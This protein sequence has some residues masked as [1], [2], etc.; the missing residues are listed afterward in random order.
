V[1]E[2]VARDVTGIPCRSR[3]RADPSS[4][5]EMAR[6]WRAPAVVGRAMSRAADLLG[7]ALWRLPVAAP[8]ADHRATAWE[9]AL[10]ASY[11]GPGRGYTS[12]L[13]TVVAVRG[14]GERLA[15][16]RELARPQRPYM[17]ARGWSPLAP[18]RDAARRI[19]ASR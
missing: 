15:S 18:L 5:V 2:T 14:A 19:W 3:V 12:Q 9:R 11:R 1:R 7:Q 4:V 17:S 6:R 13:A 8:F 10:V 16:L